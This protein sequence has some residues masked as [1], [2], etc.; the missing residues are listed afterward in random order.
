MIIRDLHTV[1]LSKCNIVRA[2][3]SPLP[4]YM[5]VISVAVAWNT[6]VFRR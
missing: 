4:Q 2:N 6:L 3:A 5:C 1:E